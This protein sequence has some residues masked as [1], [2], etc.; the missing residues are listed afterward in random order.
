MR[1]A[2]AHA[3][4]ELRARTSDASGSVV[5]MG[6]V[7][8][9][10]C[11]SGHG[12]VFEADSLESA[13]TR[14]VAPLL[15]SPRDEQIGKPSLRTD[16]FARRFCPLLPVGE[17]LGRQRLG[18]CG[19]HTTLIEPP[20]QGVLGLEVLLGCRHHAGGRFEAFTLPRKAS[21]H[22]PRENPIALSEQLLGQATIALVRAGSSP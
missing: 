10:G 9:V 4:R 17:Q 22:G 11:V 3:Y 12:R 2:H 8:R 14:A 16:E 15:Q 21:G 13:H 19:A 20:A 6:S 7:V 1:R 18:V 5:F